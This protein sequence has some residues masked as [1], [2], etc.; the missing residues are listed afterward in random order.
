MADLDPRRLVSHAIVVSSHI[1]A[2][3]LSSSCPTPLEMWKP[4]HADLEPHRPPFLHFF[5]SGLIPCN[6]ILPVL[7]GFL[8]SG[9][10]SSTRIRSDLLG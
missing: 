7:D 8:P 10:T 5:T 4:A 9:L 2:A 3:L 1:V 6:Q